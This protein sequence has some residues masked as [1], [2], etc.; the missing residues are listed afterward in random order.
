MPHHEVCDTPVSEIMHQWPVTVRVFIDRHLHCIGCPVGDF[1]TLSEAAI[2][3]GLSAVDLC[4]EVSAA[5][6]EAPGA[7]RG[8]ARRHPRS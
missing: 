5:I 1:H 3:H 2:E 7:G 4:H 6:A 8:R